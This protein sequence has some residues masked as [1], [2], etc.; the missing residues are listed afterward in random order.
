VSDIGDALTGDIVMSLA[1]SPA[2]GAHWECEIRM[3]PTATGHIVR[4]SNPET[5]RMKVVHRSRKPLTWR[6]ALDDLQALEEARFA[7][8]EAQLVEVSGVCEWQAD[9]LR[10]AACRIDVARSAESVLLAQLSDAAIENL[11]RIWGRLVSAKAREGVRELDEIHSETGALAVIEEWVLSA[12][13]DDGA[14][15]EGW[16]EEVRAACQADP[17][18]GP[19]LAAAKKV[20][21]AAQLLELAQGPPPRDPAVRAVLFRKWVDL[22]MVEAFNDNRRSLGDDPGLRSAEWLV[23]PCVQAGELAHAARGDDPLADSLRR[24]RS[25]VDTFLD[26]DLLQLPASNWASGVAQSLRTSA[27][28]R[29]RALR[30]RVCGDANGTAGQSF[31]GQP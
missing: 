12:N 23:G 13:E 1:H 8:E 4:A 21:T 16:L 22:L 15:S 3:E 11:A 5:G 24:F 7:I 18:P 2:P 10:L 29:A 19:S 31:H 14:D 26:A 25:A 6:A 9:M 17:G 20:T 28:K 27:L 30:D